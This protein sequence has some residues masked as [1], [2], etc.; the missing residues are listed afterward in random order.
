MKRNCFIN[1]NFSLTYIASADPHSI[2][3]RLCFLPKHL[4]LSPS[5][6]GLLERKKN[7]KTSSYLTLSF[8]MSVS[9]F[10]TRKLSLNFQINFIS[11]VANRTY[12]HSRNFTFY[13][14]Q[15]LSLLT[16]CRIIQHFL[17]GPRS[18]SYGRTAALRLIVQPL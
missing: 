12:R 1:G 3:S 4:V 17:E 6:Y 7:F 18:R 9:A 10:S 15:P 5:S 14:F 11:F 8:S 13:Y 16:H 2:G